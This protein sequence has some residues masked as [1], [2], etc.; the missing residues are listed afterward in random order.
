MVTQKPSD[1][2]I[3]VRRA[4]IALLC[5]CWLL[6]G[7]AVGEEP[8]GPAPAEAEAA[9][10][11]AKRTVVFPLKHAKAGA[12]ARTLRAIA[13]AQ[14]ADGKLD[15]MVSLGTD[16]EKNSIIVSAPPEAQKTIAALIEKLDVPAAGA[17]V[18]ES[19]ER[20]RRVPQM[21]APTP[22]K[23]DQQE[24]K[25]TTRVYRLKYAPAGSVYQTLSILW[26]GKDARVAAD[27]VSNS[28]IV[29]APPEVQQT[30]AQLIE[31][32]D[33]APMHGAERELKIFSLKYAD[34]QETA[35]VLSR[36]FGKDDVRIGVDPRT[37]SVVVQA[38]PETAQEIQAV[39]SRLDTEADKDAQKGAAG[40]T[41]RV[42]VVWLA[43]EL[44]AEEGAK[45]ADDLKEV[46]GELSKV[47]V[48]G[49]RQ[50]GQAIVN[51]TPDGNFQVRCSPLL[52]GRPAD[53]ELQG[54][55]KLRQETPILNVQLSA[56][57]T[58]PA[59]VVARQ[60]EGGR[61]GQPGAPSP[62]EKVMLG[63]PS[64]K[65]L[66]ELQTTITAPQGHYVVLGVTPVGKMASV[67]ILQ[68]TASK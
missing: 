12:V 15:G 55:I 67:F 50:L 64:T 44:P 3:T 10:G 48:E 61:S 29:A 52:A 18:K 66:V 31:Q 37:S 4:M 54:T 9:H 33:V 39:L 40:A 41:L 27:D 53:L 68:V 65:R 5:G 57:Q 7:L 36:I 38:L 51:T 11:G 47:G 1:R 28:I 16:E 58:E 8:K 30:T 45:P 59:P 13:E 43:S 49:L 21:F 14:V 2:L 32:L 25:S 42:R 19:G 23:G 17:A 26:Q 46:V 56:S 24:G 6:A 63:R 35:A 60:V 62:V 20:P 22:E 34:P